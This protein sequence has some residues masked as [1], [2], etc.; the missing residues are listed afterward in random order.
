MGISSS[1]C[2]VYC[3]VSITY[4]GYQ[5]A[6]IILVAGPWITTQPG[7]PEVPSVFWTTRE[8][9]QY[10]ISSELVWIELEKLCWIELQKLFTER[11]LKCLHLCLHQHM[12]TL[13]SPT[14]IVRQLLCTNHTFVNHLWTLLWFTIEPLLYPILYPLADQPT[15]NRIAKDS[16]SSSVAA[17][18]VSDR[19]KINCKKSTLDGLWSES[20]CRSSSQSQAC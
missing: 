20:N 1:K 13:V 18:Y 8:S 15:N 16:L 11:K 6:L 2:F 7:F 12:S 19:T 17:V 4:K 5:L 9:L 10:S 3:H 14:T